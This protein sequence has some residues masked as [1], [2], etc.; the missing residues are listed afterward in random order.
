M[1]GPMNYKEKTYRVFN[2]FFSSFLKDLKEVDDD[3][4]K[5]VKASYKAIDKSSSTYCEF[6]ANNVLG[7][8]KGVGALASGLSDVKECLVAEGITVGVV[9][10]HL[11]KEGAEATAAVIKN[12][13]YTLG[14]FAHLYT[15]EE[16]S[17][18]LFNQVVK[19]L[20]YIQAG[21][22]EKYNAEKEDILDDDIR[23]LLERIR[24][25]DVPKKVEGGVGAG[26]AEDLLA[27]F[28]NGK[29]ASL[30]KEIAQGIDV[31][32][33]KADNPDEMIKN[34]LDFS[35]GNNMLGN[36]IQQ[37]SSTLSNKISSGEIKHEELLGE[38]MSMMNIFN[39]AGGAGGNPLAS[40]PLFSN[41]MK[42]MK[43]GKA[44]VR[45]DVIKKGDTRDR[46]RKKLEM[47]KKNVE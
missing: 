5:L 32:S 19:V 33:L 34:M 7:G 41:I 42:S 17:D 6:F 37:V 22:L 2:R 12:Y 39:G 43:A 40:N 21:D 45:Q 47:R 38:A 35:S 46:L 23:S 20:G 15:L 3:L 10:E 44:Q 9:L 31:S 16:Q 30:A 13:I 1:S 11:G 27:G 29:I 36:I 8:E 24:E 18:E 14:L 26:G 4:R 28:G 25:C